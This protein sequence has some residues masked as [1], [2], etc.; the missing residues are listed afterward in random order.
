MPDAA[1]STID[2]EQALAVLDTYNRQ[3]EAVSRQLNFLQAILT[4]TVDARQALE[5]LEKEKSKDVLVPLGA[6]T[7]LFGTVAKTDRVISGIGSGY[8]V[9]KT[10]DEARERLKKREEDLR[11]EMQR[12]SEAAVRLQQEAGALQEEIQEGMGRMQAGGAP[13]TG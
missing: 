4:E 11:A 3:I 7:F 8:S 13:P 1:A 9:E 6:N 12:L 10:W 2:I 5:G